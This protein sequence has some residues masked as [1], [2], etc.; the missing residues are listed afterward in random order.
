V[1][2]RSGPKAQK[3]NQN[4][5]RRKNGGNISTRDSNP[6]LPSPGLT[7]LPLGHRHVCVKHAAS[8][9]YQLKKQREK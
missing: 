6:S 1:V 2:N 7:N 5:K 8:K 9:Q 4:I 3:S